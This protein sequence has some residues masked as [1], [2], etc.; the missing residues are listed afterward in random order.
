MDQHFDIGKK[1]FGIYLGT[2]VQ[3]LTHGQLKV[4]IQGIY[5]QEW[6]ET[7]ALLP[8][9]Q[10]VTPQFGGSHDGNGTFSYPNIGSTVVCMFANGDQNLPLTFGS[11]LGGMNAFG[12]YEHIKTNDELCSSR[13][14]IT[15]GKSHIEMYESGKISAVVADPIRTQAEVSYGTEVDAPLSIDAVTSRPICEKVE[16]KQLSSIDCQFVMDNFYGHGSISSST[17]W[18]DP[19]SYSTVTSS[20]NGQKI[21]S[22]NKS[23]TRQIDSYCLVD[24]DGHREF[25]HTKK[26]K[27]TTISSMVDGQSA[28]NEMAPLTSNV[29]TSFTH[30]LD[31]VNRFSTTSAVI[32]ASSY[33][34]KGPNSSEIR[35]KNNKINANSQ[36]G[37]R[38]DSSFGMSGEVNQKLVETTKKDDNVKSQ[39]IKSTNSSSILADGKNS[40]V[41]TT[42]SSS[43][44]SETDTSIGLEMHSNKHNAQAV[45]DQSSHTGIKLDSSWNDDDM[46]VLNGTTVQEKHTN[47]SNID[48]VSGENPSIGLKAQKKYKKT[49]NGSSQDY[50]VVCEET[51]SP[52]DGVVTVKITDNVTKMGCTFEMDSKGNLKISAT[53]SISID[54]PTVNITGQTMT[55]T[56]MSYVATAQTLML[57]GINGDCKVKNVSLLNHKHQETQAGDVVSPQA[58]K[59]AT[60][61]N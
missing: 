55:Q 54:A 46:Q 30:G 10:Q 57:T 32:D 31:G 6:A 14:L 39:N 8:I 58:T 23:G 47:F 45:I 13:H 1:C 60:Q 24:N 27:T 21:V 59:P 5:P 4:Y 7:P 35:T 25:G 43:R 53:T 12:Q 2:V 41:Y 42:L 44:L 34:S 49:I 51:I 15:A 19:V 50:N 56:F 16:A 40:I 48:A 9:C 22:E 36:Y 3:H 33:S 29:Q 18:F 17:H 61:S 52:T 26:V 20:D 28:S 38:V 37:Y 11:I